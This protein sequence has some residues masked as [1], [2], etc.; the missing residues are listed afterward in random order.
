[1]SDYSPHILGISEASFWTDHN[2]EDVQIPNYK[3]FL[4][5]TLKN[6]QLN[7]S[8]VAVYVHED[9]NVKIREDLMTED[10]S[11]VWLEVG[12]PRQKKFLVSHVY[13]DW[14]HMRQQDH[15]SL[16]IPEQLGRWEGFLQQWESA[17]SLGLEIHVQGDMNLNFLDFNNTDSLPSSNQSSKLKSLIAALKDCILPHG[18]CQLVQ[19]VTRTWP[20]AESTLLDHHWTN[21]PG[22]VSNVHA[23]FQGASDHKMI[24]GIRRTRKAISKPKIIRRR[25]FKDFNP[26]LF[27]AAVSNISWLEVYLCDDPDTAANLITIKINK[28]LDEMAP[29]KVIQVRTHYAPWMSKDTKAK[30]KERNIAQKKAAESQTDEDWEAFKHLRNSLTN[31]LKLEKK[32][33][34]EQKLKSFG[35]DTSSVWKNVKN[36]LGWTSGGSPTMLVEDGT[37]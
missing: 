12:L 23:Y 24:F 13:R 7:V 14:Q 35:N 4:A 20:G 33:W 8:R 2:L 19:G 21:Q 28:I 10:F 37:V 27:R 32:S 34:Q 17:V 3:L 22:E 1:M 30:A 25:S 9:I 16:S 36:W 15:T 31:T 18:F 6:P 29:V 5:N 11:S 26:E